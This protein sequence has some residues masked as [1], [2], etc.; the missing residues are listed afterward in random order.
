[1]L[2]TKNSTYKVILI[3]SLICIAAGLVLSALSIT[4][5][6]SNLPQ[7]IACLFNIA[8][9]IY[10]AYYILAGYSKDAA[11]YYKTYA[12]IFA[13]AQVAALSAIGATANSYIGTLLSAL[14]LAAILVLLFSKDLGKQKSMSLCVA[15]LVL[16]VLSF[17]SALVNEGW[18]SVVMFPII[19]R[20]VLACI[21][22]IMTVAKYIDKAARGRT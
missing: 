4:G 13:L 5:N 15:L 17:I 12:A 16:V 19:V 10:A 18:I 9:L 21:L 8:A 2:K 3:L 20:F 7:Q 22:T 6:D 11:K 1:M 14:T